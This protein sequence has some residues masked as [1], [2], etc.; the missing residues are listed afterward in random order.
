LF[1][2]CCTRGSPDSPQQ[3]VA[4][5]GQEGDIDGDTKYVIPTT[6]EEK[7]VCL[8]AAAMKEHAGGFEDRFYPLWQEWT[9]H[10]IKDI[11]GLF[12]SPQ[13]WAG[14][15]IEDPRLSDLGKRVP[16]GTICLAQLQRKAFNFQGKAPYY[17]HSV[18]KARIT[19]FVGEEIK[20]FPPDF[21]EAL[22]FIRGG[23]GSALPSNPPSPQ[24]PNPNE[25][26]V[27]ENNPT[28]RHGVQTRRFSKRIAEANA[29][30]AN[31]DTANLDRFKNKNANDDD[32]DDRN[33]ESA[34]PTYKPGAAVQRKPR[35][36][37][38]AEH[39]VDKYGDMDLLRL[40][41]TLLN[42][43]WERAELEA[44]EQAARFL[45]DDPHCKRIIL[46]AMVGTRWKY[47]ECRRTRGQEPVDRETSTSYGSENDI[48]LIPVRWR[49][50]KDG[51]H[52]LTEQSFATEEIIRRKLR[53]LADEYGADDEVAKAT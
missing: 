45:A 43:S 36:I 1:S 53:E 17:H 16:D 31:I 29:K 48:N 34:D 20:P 11:T 12:H 30:E 15:R 51:G 27:A 22:N 9:Q 37:K 32:D 13:R 44:S 19:V 40:E 47:T 35:N 46:T 8:A 52:V 49:K 38:K 23:P 39:F 25:S 7:M 21:I 2:T 4:V 41:E 6:Y 50:F 42:S 14:R 28:N 33:S 18:K 10:L 3:I 26:Q 24:S 5:H